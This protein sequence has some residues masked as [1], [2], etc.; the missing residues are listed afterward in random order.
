MLIGRF[1]LGVHDSTKRWED[2]SSVG[3][4]LHPDHEVLLSPFPHTHTNTHTSL[5]WLQSVS[6]QPSRCPP[7]CPSCWKRWCRGGSEGPSEG[8][9][10]PRRASA[11]DSS[12][13]VGRTV[14]SPGRS[15]S[16]H[17]PT[18][19][20]TCLTRNWQSSRVF[21]TL[22][23]T[24]LLSTC[25]TCWR[26]LRERNHIYGYNCITKQQLYEPWSAPLFYCCYADGT[27]IILS[28]LVNN[29][30]LYSWPSRYANL[31][32]PQ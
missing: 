22:S 26:P 17:T 8:P 3:H 25:L 4:T 7:A 20:W 9:P 19:W 5:T 30:T 14:V 1:R 32:Y 2:P 13:N 29:Q 21:T 28:L 16:L 11:S 27:E 18:C 31:F 6:S 10:S 23:F 12:T 15:R 24:S